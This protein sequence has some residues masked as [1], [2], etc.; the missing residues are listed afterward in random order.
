MCLLHSLPD[1][2]RR[3]ALV[4]FHEGEL[5][6]MLSF[7]SAGSWP[8][9]SSLCKS[10]AVLLTVRREGG[11]VQSGDWENLA[12][13]STSMHTGSGG[14]GKDA[15]TCALRLPPSFIRSPLPP[16]PQCSGS[17]SP[18]LRL[19]ARVS[20]CLW[21]RL[22]HSGPSG[23]PFGGDGSREVGGSTWRWGW[24]KRRKATILAKTSVHH[25]QDVQPNFSVRSKSVSP[26]V[27]LNRGSGALWRHMEMCGG[28]FSCLPAWEFSGSGPGMLNG[29]QWAAQTRSEELSGLK[30][31]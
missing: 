1:T 12:V 15:F 3:S 5:G 25:T 11:R 2:R 7:L 16:P 24:R 30:C 8:H 27:V 13:G 6:Q 4:K 9:S 21:L 19:L 20:L 26:A 17:L 29:L 14:W 31:P 22:S 10:F 23:L 18:S 28:I